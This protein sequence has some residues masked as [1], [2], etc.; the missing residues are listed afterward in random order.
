LDPLFP[1]IFG[2]FLVIF[3]FTVFVRVRVGRFGP[4]PTFGGRKHE[5]V[6]DYRNF[7]TKSAKSAKKVCKK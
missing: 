4:T 5:K 6:A 2:I 1:S 7:V 3:W